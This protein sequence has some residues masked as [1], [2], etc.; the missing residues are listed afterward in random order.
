MNED[1][2]SCCLGNGIHSG[3]YLKNISGSR[4]FPSR[5]IKY[6]KN[7]KNKRRNKNKK[8]EETIKI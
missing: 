2:Q 3:T 5:K 1:E 8:K 4:K 6:K 7:K